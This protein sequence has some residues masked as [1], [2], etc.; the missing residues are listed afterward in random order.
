MAD[1]FVSDVH[2]CLDRA[3]RAERLVRFVGDL[4][5]SDTLTIG[6]D[7]CDFWFASREV[8]RQPLSCPGLA[9]LAEFVQSGGQ[10]T[11]IR[12]NHDTW[13]DRFYASRLGARVLDE[14]IQLV[15]YGRRVHLVH[16][17]LI[18]SG[19][20]WKRMLESRMFLRVFGSLPQPLALLLRA[21]LDR[22]NQR[23]RTTQISQHVSVFRR[24]VQQHSE[25]AE[26]FLFGHVHEATDEQIGAARMIVLGSWIRGMSYLRIDE[27]GPSFVVES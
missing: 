13:L 23:G 2:L 6:G 19:S 17:H 11:I 21:R 25:T 3:I 12:G 26:L 15:S 8:R 14:P 5:V 4:D 16:G 7:L 9:I 20:W 10:L 24:Y 18:S 27:N 22:V 1:Y